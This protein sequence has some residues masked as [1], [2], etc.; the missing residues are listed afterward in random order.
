MTLNLEP[1]IFTVFDDGAGKDI[2]NPAPGRPATKV[3]Q[4]T[5]KSKKRETGFVIYDTL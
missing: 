2:N 5:T 1:A 4:I 3:S